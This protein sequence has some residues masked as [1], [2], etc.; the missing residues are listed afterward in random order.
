MVCLVLLS[1]HKAFPCSHAEMNI[2]AQCILL[3]SIK[4][5]IKVS[6]YNNNIAL[7]NNKISVRVIYKFFWETNK[8]KY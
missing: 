4:T 5:N 2:I 1:E 7:L 3:P 6:P 8:T